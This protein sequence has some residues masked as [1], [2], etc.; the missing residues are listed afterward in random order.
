ML[1]VKKKNLLDRNSK[2]GI[3]I[4]FVSETLLIS[5]RTSGKSLTKLSGISKIIKV[6]A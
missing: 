5:K 4:T 3:A 2:T 6:S 1:R